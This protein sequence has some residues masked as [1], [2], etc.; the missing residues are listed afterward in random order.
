[1]HGAV[2]GGQG[3]A[4]GP[5]IAR[6]VQ[7]PPACRIARIHLF[8]P[9]R[10]TSYLGDD[11]LP[12]SKK[13]RALLGYLCL[14]PG[15]KVARLRLARLLWDQTTDEHARGSLRHALLDVCEAMGPLATELISAGRTAVRLNADAC[16]I[17][18]VAM[19]DD[20]SSPGSELARFCPGQLLEGLDG[21]SVSFDQW[22]VRERTRF[23]EKTKGYLPPQTENYA[24]QS[25]PG[26]NRLRVAVL[27]FEELGDGKCPERDEDFGFSLSRDIAAALARFRWFDVVTSISLIAR[28]LVNFTSEDFLQRNELDYAVDGLIIRHEESMEIKVRLLDLTRRTRPVWSERFELKARELHRLNEMVTGRVVSNID[29]IILYIEG[30]PNRREHYGATGLLLLALPLV[31]SMDR[32]KFKRAGE[33]IHQ[34]MEIDPQNAVALAWAA[35]WHLTRVGQGWAQDLAAALATAE[36]LCLKSIEID[37][38]NAEALGIYAHI[39][40]WKKDFDAAVHYFNRSLRLNPNLAFIWALS[41]AT[42]CYIG[43]PV[44]A[45]QRL[46]R[47]RD[48][49]PFDP[50]F[51]IYE[52][53]Y[54]L[55]YMFK[56]D[57][58]QAV[59]IGRG[60]VKANPDYSASYKP[61]IAALGHLGRGDEAKPYIDKLLSLEPH[62][63]VEHFARTY[64]FKRPED[65]RRYARG[66]RLAGVPER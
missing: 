65:R 36:S 5:D 54:A 34:A 49:A 52:G 32:V 19:L 2:S 3:A 56:G 1:M 12:S 30:Q 35:W 63:T 29:P 33:L 13:G 42:Y 4:V 37:S 57:Y 22:L 64:P 23:G 17:D 24:R 59:L 55:A 28:P 41:A 44:I 51:C 61:L 27:P 21:L 6:L 14:A 8:G 38:D 48:L 40:A 50:Y 66:L 39:C 60:A 31:F 16:W 18:A 15:T 11:I 43:E 47:Y 62:F 9:M 7:R 20:P 58:E 26:R 53:V 25:L 45:L 46:K 10:A